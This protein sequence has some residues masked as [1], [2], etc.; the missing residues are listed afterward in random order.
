MGIPNRLGTALVA[1]TALLTPTVAAA[2]DETAHVLQPS[3]PWNLEYGLESCTLSRNF[4]EGDATLS[5]YLTQT[6]PEAGFDLKIAGTSLGKPRRAF[7]TTLRLGEQEERKFK[8]TV[9]IAEADDGRP[10]LLLGP[11]S[12]AGQ[13]PDAKDLP[14]G[15]EADPKS[16]ERVAFDVP[17]AGA[18]VLET[19]A[20]DAPMTAMKTCE[21]DLVK[22]WGFDP[23]QVASLSQEPTPLT[24]IATW[25]SPNTYPDEQRRNREGAILDFRIIVNTEGR[26]ENCV[27][28][29]SVGDD[30]FIASACR[31]LMLNA[32]FSPALDASGQPVR[33]LWFKRVRY[34][35]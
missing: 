16:I 2:K 17:K 21:D 11:T 18:F 1:A 8:D 20:M 10:V 32:R 19:G 30:V 27:I 26:A 35:S 29:N 9:W 31:E 25:I 7:G 5:L 12:F 6:H 14:P 15:P 28:Q 23:A 24:N 13:D 3:T 34:Q 22:T 33:A 4:G